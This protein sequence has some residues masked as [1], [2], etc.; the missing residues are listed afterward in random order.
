MLTP[1]S[2]I[3]V[4]GHRGMVG[5]AIVRNLEK[6][7]ITNLITR[8]HEELNLANQQQV[9][10]F[11]E[12]EKPNVVILAAAKVGGIHAN[13][14]YPAD[15]IYENLMIESNVIHSAYLNN[16]KRLLFLGSSC[17]YLKQ[18]LSQCVKMLY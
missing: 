9:N 10:S 17:I 6:R 13:N 11:F 18:L 3:Y 14:T 16:V 12:T 5:S 1:D 15:F 4:A 8:T 7:G 2:R